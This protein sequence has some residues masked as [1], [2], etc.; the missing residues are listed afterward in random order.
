MGCRSSS[1][2]YVVAAD[3]TGRL[4]LQRGH[5]KLLLKYAPH[6]VPTRAPTATDEDLMTQSWDDIIGC[7]LR[8]EIERRK[9]PSTEPSP[10]APTTTSAIVQFY[11]TFFS[12]LYVINPETRSVFRNS[13]HVQ[14]KAL[15]NIVGA[16]RHVLH[17]DDA[18]NM[19]AAMAVRHIQYGVKLEYFDNL[20]VAMIQTLSKLAGTTWT[21]AMADAWH[22]VIAYIICLIVPHY[23]K[24]K[25]TKNHQH[26]LG[27]VASLSTRVNIMRVA[28]DYAGPPVP[29]PQ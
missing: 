27:R 22:T 24:G 11:D 7:K 5:K 20:G 29:A 6:F 21:T 19:V 12:H 10:E 8:A 1:E 15:V 26:L 2:R 16:I 14:S 3:S 9:A 25:H 28:V 13:M 17:S 4:V 23:M 18:K